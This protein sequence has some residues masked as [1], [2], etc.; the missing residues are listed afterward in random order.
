VSC[1]AVLFDLDGTLLNTISDLADSMNTVLNNAGLPIHNTEAYKYFVGKGMKNLTYKAL[2][3]DYRTDDRI[4]KYEKELL[5][6]YEK[7]WDIKTKPYDGI[8]KMLD[9]LVCY[10]IR[11]SVLSNKT[12]QFTKKTVKRFLSAWKFEYVF[13]E[14]EGIPKKPDPMSAIEIAGLMN[15]N[16]EDFIY[17]GDSET[18]MRTARA[19]GMYPVGAG[20]GFRKIKELIS[21]GAKKIINRPEELEDIL[22]IN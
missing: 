3:V 6:E 20:W 7:R 11:M 10:G 21:S 8:G 19:A 1:R 22:L 14:R 17:L 12:D 2:P 4:E 15:L 18:D 9:M 13:G 16:T 5:E